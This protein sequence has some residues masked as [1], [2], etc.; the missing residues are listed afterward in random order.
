M[1]KCR[2]L[3]EKG[4]CQIGQLALHTLDQL[5]DFPDLTALV[6]GD[7]DVPSKASLATGIV[8]LGNTGEFRTVFVV[9]CTA[10][11]DVAKQPDCDTFVS[12]KR[13]SSAQWLENFSEG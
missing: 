13:I 5:P 7:V 3:S 6:C 8:E 4:M 11:A 1:E 9:K 2:F 12:K 10:V